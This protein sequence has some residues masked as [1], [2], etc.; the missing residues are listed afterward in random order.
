MSQKNSNPPPTKPIYTAFHK[1]FPLIYFP[2][3]IRSAHESMPAP[4]EP[5]APPARVRRARA[6]RRWITVPSFGMVGLVFFNIILGYPFFAPAACFL[7]I[8]ITPPFA[9]FGLYRYMQRAMEE[10][11]AADVKAHEQLLAEHAIA[12]RRFKAQKDAPVTEA[13]IQAHRHQLVIKRLKTQTAA[14]KRLRR[15]TARG[16]SE[17]RFY[18]YLVRHFGRTYIRKSMQLGDF[19]LPYA[20]DFCWIDES[21]GLHIDI[22][23]DEPYV[24][25][26]LEAIH[27]KGADTDRND[28]FTLQGWVVIRFSEE[29]IVKYP[30]ACCEQIEALRQF[31]L[32]LRTDLPTIVPVAPL[33][34]RR[35]AEE[36]A[37]K[38]SR[39]YFK[40]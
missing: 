4:V 3:Y 38:G 25:N 24:A 39:N 28:Y 37:Q 17:E 21:T 27:Y 10:Q 36:M 8:I 12:V 32:Y 26:T 13:A 16:R 5:P 7:L 14:P 31:V 30:E 34:S 22:E 18:E 9:Y 6:S 35:E 29:Q 1:Q 23:I 2:A 15:I 19:E 11:Y 40:G 20:P 33:W